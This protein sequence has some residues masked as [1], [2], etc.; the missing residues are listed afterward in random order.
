MLQDRGEVILNL[1]S[2]SLIGGAFVE[3]VIGFCDQSVWYIQIKT[4][5]TAETYRV[6]ISFPDGPYISPFCNSEFLKRPIWV[7]PLELM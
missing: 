3:W 1:Y 5:E 6:P 4:R 2:E 7:S